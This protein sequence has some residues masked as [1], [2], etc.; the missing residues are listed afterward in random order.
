MTL[1]Q[2]LGHSNINTTAVYLRFNDQTYKKCMQT[3]RSSVETKKG[4]KGSANA[5]C[6]SR[7]ITASLQFVLLGL[8]HIQ[9]YN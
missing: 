2:M 4:K 5:P 6:H 7:R 3:C 8:L 1:Q 9:G